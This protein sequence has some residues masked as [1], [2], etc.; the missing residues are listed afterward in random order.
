MPVELTADADLRDGRINLA[1]IWTSPGLQQWPDDLRLVRRT[2]TY[3]EDHEDGRCLFQLNDLTGSAPERRIERT[4]LLVPRPPLSEP[5]SSACFSQPT[6]DWIKQAELVVYFDSSDTSRPLRAV[7][8]IFNNGSGTMETV[9]TIDDLKLVKR[10]HI[11]DSKWQSVE[12]I[13]IVTAA[14]ADPVQATTTFELYRGSYTKGTRDKLRWQCP[15]EAKQQVEFDRF[16]LEV[17]RVHSRL[18]PDL[19]EWC[20][21]FKIADQ[22]SLPET[23]SYYTLFA[24]GPEGWYSERPWRAAAMATAS[25][26]LAE[27]LYQLL[28]KVLRSFDE[29][30]PELAGQGQLRAFVSIFG[31]SLDHLRSLA[32]G[33]KLRHDVHQVD[34]AMLPSLARWIGWEPDQTLDVLSQRSNILVAPELFGSLGTVP[35]LEALVNRVTGWPCLIKELGN[36]VFLTN[37]PEPVHLWEIWEYTAALSEPIRLTRSEGLDGRP[38]AVVD[39]TGAIWLLWHSDG[40]GHR[41]LWLQRP[42]IDPS[43]RPVLPEGQV[44]QYGTPDFSDES[45]AAVTMGQTIRLFWCSNRDG[46]WDIWTCAIDSTDLSSGPPERLTRHTAADRNPAVVKDATGRIWLLWESDRR[47]PTDIW[48]QIYE[49]PDG[50]GSPFRVTT[51]VTRHQMPSAVIDGSGRLWLFWCADLGDRSEIHYQTYPD[52]TQSGGAW[53]QPAAVP[54]SQGRNEAPAAIFWSNHVWLLWHSNRDGH[55]QIW[56]QS[57]N[58]PGPGWGSPRSVNEHPGA[59]KEP[60]AVIDSSH[61]LHLYWRS[62]RRGLGYRSRTIDV[63][64]PEMLAKLGTFGDRAHYTCDTGV[65]NEDWYSRGTVGIYLVP[66]GG[67]EEVARH[68]A[69]LK[70]FLEPFRPLPVRYVWIDDSESYEETVNT[71]GLIGEELVDELL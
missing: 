42:G 61:R 54:E 35:N 11:V 10:S 33:L 37:A 29:P 55:W 6:A 41:R 14:V 60:C 63:N 53:S 67:G 57:S 12:K 21:R 4:L 64:D 32:E 13:E 69:R 18:D 43:P 56:A 48:A 2:R 66:D 49:E 16:A 26:G 30:A 47:G 70:A 46:A 62:Q 5:E 15:G 58:S 8:S 20:H 44:D 22:S 28:P 24:A 34:A 71:T 36:N 50:W 31:T 39:S 3:P 52:A 59:D 65:A 9:T 17:A 27:Q 45:P 19:G 23:V 51:A 40:D 7:L 38:A 1:W 25:Y 68:L